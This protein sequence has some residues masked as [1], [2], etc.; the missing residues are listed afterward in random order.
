MTKRLSS[1]HYHLEAGKQ[2]LPDATAHE[3]EFKKWLSKYSFSLIHRS[4]AHLQPD[5]DPVA[6]KTW[7]KH[8]FCL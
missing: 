2:A 5:I 8:L 6:A 1:Y 3:F 7:Q 4:H